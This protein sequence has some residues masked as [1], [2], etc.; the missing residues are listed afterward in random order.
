MGGVFGLLDSEVDPMFRLER[1]GVFEELLEATVLTPTS[2]VWPNE[3]SRLSELACPDMLHVFSSSLNCTL[4]HLDFSL[5]WH[6]NLTLT[7]DGFLTKPLVMTWLQMFILCF[8]LT[9]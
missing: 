5:E 1:P 7:L 4:F 8:T 3:V 9:Q 2:V 6:P